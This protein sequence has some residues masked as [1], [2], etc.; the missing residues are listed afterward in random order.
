MEVVYTVAGVE[1]HLN[2]VRKEGFVIGFVP[3]MGALHKG[4]ISLIE[5]AKEKSDFVVCSIFVNPVQF[6]DA[7][8]LKNYPR[9]PDDD[10]VV[11]KE[12]GCD[13]LFMPSVREVYP[14]GDIKEQFDFA[15]LDKVMEGIRRPGHFNGVAM[16]VKRL[17]EIVKPRKA[18]FGLKDYQQFCIIKKM[19]DNFN[20]PVEILG[21]ETVREVNGLA[22]SSRNKR[23]SSEQRERASIIFSMLSMVKE[24]LN[25][26]TPDEAKEKVVSAINSQKDMTVDY[27]II[28]DISSLQPITQWA[29]TDSA[30]AFIA[31]QVGPVRLIDNLKLY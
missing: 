14:D 7:S 11:L 6:N 23:L 28:A 31:V 2:K 1:K 30:A 9:T 21:C 3:T 19:R 18:F 8:D 5:A 16:V 13:L 12:A 17:F 15:Q 10:M 24:Q 22:M 27:F 4:H 26:L 20:L 25:T 29:E